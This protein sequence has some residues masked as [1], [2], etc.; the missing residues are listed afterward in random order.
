MVTTTVTARGQITLPKS[1]RKALHLMPG[2]RVELLPQ[3]DGTV[4][5]VPLTL[6]LAEIQAAIPPPPRALSLSE[7]DEAIRRHAVRRHRRPS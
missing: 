2:H 3:D 5:L 7:M 4:L 6:T 1:L